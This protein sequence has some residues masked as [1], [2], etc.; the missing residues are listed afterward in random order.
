MSY[1]VQFRGGEFHIDRKNMKPAENAL[2]AYR[3]RCGYDVAN[4]ATLVDML[5]DCCWVPEMDGN[6]DIN[7]IYLDDDYIGD[8]E[9]WFEEI[10][11]FVRRGSH[12]A[13]EG[14]DGYIWC[15]YFDGR[16]CTQHHGVITFPSIMDTKITIET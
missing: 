3:M 5:C 8:E 11:P 15:F 16:H 9:D 13:L 4:D 1:S 6:G 7:Y 2:R 14:D 10:A 12:L